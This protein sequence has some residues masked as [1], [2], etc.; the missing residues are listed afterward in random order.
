MKASVTILIT[1]LLMAAESY[2]RTSSA[3]RWCSAGQ[4]AQELCW[5]LEE[6]LRTIA[7]V[8][9]FSFVC[10]NGRHILDCLEK[11]SNDEADVMALDPNYVYVAG[12]YYNLVVALTETVNGS[13]S[14]F[15]YSEETV[16]V[17]RRSSFPSGRLSHF[18]GKTV[19]LSQ[20]D[21]QNL[22][23][24]ALVGVLIPLGIVPSNLRNCSSVIETLS[25]F[26]GPSCAPGQWTKTAQNEVRQ[27]LCA[28]CNDECDEH[29]REAVEQRAL[30]SDEYGYLCLQRNINSLNESCPWLIKQNWAYVT[31]AHLPAEKSL[32]VKKAIR[33]LFQMFSENR[34]M[35][36][37]ELL[38][39]GSFITG[40][41]DVYYQSTY[42][43][44]LGKIFVRSM[45]TTFP[46]VW[47][48][49][50]LL[51]WCVYDEAGM[52]KCKQMMMTWQSVRLRPRLF[53]VFS[54]DVKHC[55]Q[56]ISDNKADILVANADDAIDSIIR[57]D[58]TPVA[59]EMSDDIV[60]G[61]VLAIIR[62]NSTISLDTLFG[63][64]A[65]FGQSNPSQTTDV[66]V[67]NVLAKFGLLSMHKCNWKQAKNDFFR[68][69]SC[70]APSNDHNDTGQEPDIAFV[71]WQKPFDHHL[72][73]VDGLY[74]L[75]CLNGRRR[76]FS[77]YETCHW[78]RIPRR[79]VMCSTMHKTIAEREAIVDLLLNADKQYSKHYNDGFSMFATPMDERS[80]FDRSTISL[81]AI[82]PNES[83]IDI[84][85]AQYFDIQQQTIQ[86]MTSTSQSLSLNVCS[87][88]LLISWPF[89]VWLSCS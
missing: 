5:L 50:P 52:T 77:E 31:K 63:L 66:Y 2:D 15:S 32:A 83:V 88:M 22:Q 47:C 41:H 24:H 20:I 44:F 25:K 78:L 48:E 33:S 8:P 21:D 11:I 37:N 40:I 35:W 38:F 46:D 86:C 4:D 39:P 12:K 75:L 67:M 7:T 34:S 80:L 68:L 56:M 89:G 81:K 62:S 9:S 23:Y 72:M 36:F 14:G 60:W 19:C 49:E 55:A 69:T 45:E 26:I 17:I 76:P 79:V 53:C 27:K 74:E 61:Y 42:E 13:D 87:V 70:P 59:S 6:D 65:C 85:G 30:D 58:L 84:F 64:R 1:M 16:V 71:Q 51:R 73:N 3:V 18:S 28:L 10:I 43:R 29:D 82:S 54:E 57:H